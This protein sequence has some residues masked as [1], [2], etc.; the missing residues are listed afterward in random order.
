ME[1]RT[2]FNTTPQDDPGYIELHYIELHATQYNTA[3]DDIDGKDHAWHNI[4][5]DHMLPT[6]KLTTTYINRCCLQ[7]ASAIP[8]VSGCGDQG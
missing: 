6:T 5:G 1:I 8:L 4:I 7:A 3:V 2:S